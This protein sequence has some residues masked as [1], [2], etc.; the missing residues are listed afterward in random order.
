MGER[1]LRTI[2]SECIENL[3]ILQSDLHLKVVMLIKNF[4]IEPIRI[5]T[6]PGLRINI[7]IMF[8]FAN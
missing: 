1:K 3:S 7:N 4:N 8:F 2:E 5:Q 6:E